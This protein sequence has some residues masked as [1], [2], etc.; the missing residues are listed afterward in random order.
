MLSFR[1]RRQLERLRRRVARLVH[2]K[3]GFVTV[4]RHLKRP[5]STVRNWAHREVVPSAEALIQL[6]NTYHV[7]LDWLLGGSAG[8]TA[9]MSTNKKD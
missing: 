2:D 9:R 8:E 6:S 5:H 3:G 7:S 1:D 4:A